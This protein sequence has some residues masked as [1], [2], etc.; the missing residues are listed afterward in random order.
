V[1]TSPDPRQLAKQTLAEYDR[2]G[3]M[4]HPLAVQL[5]RD[6]L[7]ALDALDEARKETV[8]ARRLSVLAQERLLPDLR[9]AEAERDRLQADLDQTHIAMGKLIDG[10]PEAMKRLAD[11]RAALASMEGGKDA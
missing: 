2:L 7:S 3:V 9:A 1:S 5:A 11:A 6:L 10:D 4:G 8:E